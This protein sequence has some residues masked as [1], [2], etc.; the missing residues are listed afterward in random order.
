[1]VSVCSS[2]AVAQG[3]APQ[4]TRDYV[5]P[6]RTELVR[7][8]SEFLKIPNVAADPAGLR[9]N[10]DFLVEQLKRRGVETR[11]LRTRRRT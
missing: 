4:V 6:R 2:M 3:A 9:R 7:Q 8:F 11:L 1:M 5:T 10:A